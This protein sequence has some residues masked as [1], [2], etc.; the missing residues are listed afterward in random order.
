M[1]SR[2]LKIWEVAVQ[3]CIPTLTLLGFLLV[4][5]EM[6]AYGVVVSLSAQPFW[7]YSAYRSWKDAKQV[8][9]FVN[10]VMATVIFAYG[11]LNYW[12]I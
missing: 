5:M 3:V 6:P 11:V 10:S 12:F 4:S 2:G 9:I 1:E 8:G 7:L